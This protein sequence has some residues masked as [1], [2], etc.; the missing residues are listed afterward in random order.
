M[1]GQRGGDDWSLTEVKGT[2]EELHGWKFAFRRP[3]DVSSLVASR[4][5]CYAINE[6]STDNGSEPRVS[7]SG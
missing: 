1:P 5:S 4:E 6:L 3:W 7:I 2:V